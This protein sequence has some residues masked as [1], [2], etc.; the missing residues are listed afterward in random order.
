MGQRL[1][2]VLATTSAIMLDWLR[3][4]T[5]NGAIGPGLNSRGRECTDYPAR[6]A[7]RN[8]MAGN[9]TTNNR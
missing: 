7:L 4:K 6:D 2:G 3:A 8:G 1:R 9:Q 5:L